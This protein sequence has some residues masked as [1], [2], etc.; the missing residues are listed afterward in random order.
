MPPVCTILTVGSVLTVLSLMNVHG[1]PTGAPISA[2]ET[3]VPGHVRTSAQ[4]SLAPYSIHLS[5]SMYSR[6][7]P[8]T[9]TII[10][11]QYGGILLQARPIRHTQPY[12]TF[13]SP[14]KGFKTINCSNP[15]DSLTHSINS[16]RQNVSFTWNPASHAVGDIEFVATI[17]QNHNVY[18]VGVRSAVL[19]NANPTTAVFTTEA[20]TTIAMTTAEATTIDMTTDAATD[21]YTNIIT[22]GSDGSGSGSSAHYQNIFIIIVVNVIITLTM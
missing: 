1:Y 17:A 3:M 13:P 19:S 18:W 12:G 2:C 8:L 6:D 9:V 7:E 21:V 5:S 11:P 22:Y 14:H 4:T 16:L 10:G 15:F 20:A